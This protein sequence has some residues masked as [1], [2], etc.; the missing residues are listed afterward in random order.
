[1]EAR[2]SIGVASSVPRHAESLAAVTSTWTKAQGIRFLTAT[3]GGQTVTVYPGSTLM[4]RSP[5]LLEIPLDERQRLGLTPE[6]TLA[7][8]KA[9]PQHRLPQARLADCITGLETLGGDGPR[10]VAEALRLAERGPEAPPPVVIPAAPRPRAAP[11]VELP[12]H[13]AVVDRVADRPVPASAPTTAVAP[14]PGATWGWTP[15]AMRPSTAV[16]DWF[17]QDRATGLTTLLDRLGDRSTAASRIAAHLTSS[18]ACR[19]W[20]LRIDERGYVRAD[21]RAVVVIDTET[22]GGSHE[23]SALLS[24]SLRLL[25]VDPARRQAFIGY[26]LP[27]SQEVRPEAIATNGLTMNRLRELGAGSERGL[28]ED[29]KRF[30]IGVKESTGAERLM[31]VAQNAPFD[32][33]FL[34]AAAGRTWTALPLEKEWLCSLRTIRAVKALAGEPA[35]GNSLDE[36][37]QFVSGQPSPRGDTHLA[38]QDTALLAEVVIGLS[39][40]GVPLAEI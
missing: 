22:G 28:L 16:P 2:S 17:P 5:V 25:A 40:A 10:L 20:T 3:A 30:L 23:R 39:T 37:Y 11:V 34:Q 14:Q 31:A 6:K 12:P 4:V 21:D 19:P 29:V 26:A 38:D 15:V 33:R 9:I 7:T 18:V 36:V 32:R 35:G 1:M 24:V 27:G 13:R 8:S